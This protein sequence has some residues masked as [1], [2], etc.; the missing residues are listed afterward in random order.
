MYDYKFGSYF[1]S[2]VRHL[3]WEHNK[4]VVFIDVIVDKRTKHDGYYVE[5]R[6]GTHGLRTSEEVDTIV[7]SYRDLANQ[8]ALDQE[9]E[10]APD[11]GL[12]AKPS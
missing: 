3:T 10:L 5:E 11:V 9:Y 12:S 1:I 8:E 4:P 6:H 7:E 2:I